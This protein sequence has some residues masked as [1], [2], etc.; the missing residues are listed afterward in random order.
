[1]LGD[2]D[3]M[4]TLEETVTVY[5]NLLNAQLCILPNTPH[6]LEQVN[7]DLLAYVIYTFLS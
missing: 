2:R 3:K 7:V 6:P 5:K 4:V 1:M